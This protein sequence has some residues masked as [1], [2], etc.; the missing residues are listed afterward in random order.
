MQPQPAAAAAAGGAQPA[1]PTTAEVCERVKAGTAWQQRVMDGINALGQQLN[2]F[3][4]LA[5]AGNASLLSLEHQLAARTVEEAA[6][7][8][9]ADAQR[10][11]VPRTH[12]PALQWADRGSGSRGK[13]GDEG[14]APPLQ[15][16]LP[17][18]RSAAAFAQECPGSP[19]VDHPTQQTAAAS[20]SAAA[21]STG[22]PNGSILSSPR[23]T[24]ATAPLAQPEPLHS[25]DLSGS[26][27]AG[28]WDEAVEDEE[29]SPAAAEAIGTA[30][31]QPQQRSEQRRVEPQQDVEREAEARHEAMQV[32][33]D[34]VHEGEEEEGGD[35]EGEEVQIA[36]PA[37]DTVFHY[38]LQGE[39]CEGTAWL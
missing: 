33:Q 5:R 18:S 36:D 26:P 16:L 24:A 38:V 12:E 31:A 6:A 7:S 2:V 3:M 8:A 34:E 11:F 39:P 14:G 4:E 32:D 22:R 10:R 35:E 37:V 21:D 20:P 29:V 30:A 1:A 28:G 27:A 9:A 19:A 25:D 15:P 17:G 23:A 13:H